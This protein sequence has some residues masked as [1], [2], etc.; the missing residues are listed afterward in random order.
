MKQYILFFPLLCILFSVKS[1]ATTKDSLKIVLQSVTFNE[2]KLEVI[3]NLMDL[4][5]KEEQLDYAKVLY[6]EALKNKDSYYKEIALTEILRYYVNNDIKDSTNYYLAEVDR[7]LKGIAKENL[8]AY[9]KTIMDVRV[10]YYTKNDESRKILEEKLTQLKTDKDLDVFEQM[11]INYILAMAISNK[12]QPEESDK[13]Y[14]EMVSYFK[15]VIHLSNKIPLRYSILF[16]LNSYFMIA[17][18]SIDAQ[19]RIEYAKQYLSVL[20]EYAEIKGLPKRPYTNRRHYLNAYSI[21][22]SSAPV[23][24]KLQANFYYKK[25]LETSKLYPEDANVCPEYEYLFTSINYYQ[26]ISDYERALPLYDSIISFFRRANFS[27]N[28]VLTLKDKIAAYDSLHKYKEAYETYKE[29]AT[30]VDSARIKN[31]SNQIEDLEI[32][33]NV[34]QLIIE[35]TSLELDLA[36]NKTRLFFIFTLFLIVLS[37]SVFVVFRL[38]KTK[39][40][41]KEL[42][43]SNRQV[44]IAKA[45]AEEGEKMKNAFIKNMCHEVRTPLNAINGFSELI[46]NE[47][48]PLEEKK[49]FSKIIFN[50]CNQLTLLVNDILEISQ[51]DSNDDTP[52]MEQTNIFP[53]CVA[54]MNNIKKLQIKDGIEYKVEGDKENDVIYT[55]HNY[56][57]LILSHLLNNANKFTD[58]GHIILAFQVNYKEK[59]VV[60]SVTDT[61]C[62]IPTDKK[63]WIFE[64]FTKNNDFVPG[65]GLGLYLCRLI[66]RRLNGDIILDTDYINGARFVITLPIT[67]T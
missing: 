59:N 4:S 24:G 54:E 16:K 36:K 35:K 9:M 5:R 28:V 10:V 8:Q 51:L 52:A 14:T 21:L 40:L 43:E 26:G 55:N 12:I 11:S 17:T 23:L 6:Q 30:L 39:K 47:E 53:I 58:R 56:L 32:Q 62:G 29:Y 27:D 64:R 38:G 49:E 66:A 50:N 48:I 67:Q 45:K 46:T 44:V 34:N 42:Q 61:G 33:K 57:G 2:C 60:I 31:I 65:S 22:S 13:Q 7:E 15:K 25:F 37:I 1:Q 19:E 3:M 63:E 18:C 20:N 41:F